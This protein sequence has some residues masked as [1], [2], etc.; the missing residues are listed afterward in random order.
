VEKVTADQEPS[1]KSF[2]PIDHHCPMYC[3]IYS[4][5]RRK[6]LHYLEIFAWRSLIRE[7]FNHSR[8][9]QYRSDAVGELFE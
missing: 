1:N 5:G 4:L 2:N 9:A 6:M 3:T 8:S 7:T